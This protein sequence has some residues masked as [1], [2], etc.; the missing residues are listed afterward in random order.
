M[1]IWETYDWFTEKK[2]DKTNVKIIQCELM[3]RKLVSRNWNIIITEFRS[4]IQNT[5]SSYTRPVYALLVGSQLS[6]SWTRRII[7]TPIKIPEF[8][9]ASEPVISILIISISNFI[10]R[11]SKGPEARRQRARDGFPRY[12]IAPWCSR[13][14]YPPTVG[15]QWSEVVGRRFNNEMKSM[16]D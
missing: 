14:I 4:R 1:T 10:T 9:I 6:Y 13:I 16:G 11:T 3:M 8:C 2:N 15:N 7:Y 5:R 12:S